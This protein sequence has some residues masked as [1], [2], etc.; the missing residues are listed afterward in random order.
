M[1]AFYLS[2]KLIQKVNSS[3]IGLFTY[4]N[5]EVN[6]MNE[7]RVTGVVVDAGHG[8]IGVSQK[9]GNDYEC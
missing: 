2:N 1:N 9:Q 6:I 4:F 5:V 7:R 8:G 3:K